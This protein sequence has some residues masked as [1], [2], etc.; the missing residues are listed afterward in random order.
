MESYTSQIESILTGPMVG[1]WSV[2]LLEALSKKKKARVWNIL[3]YP[4]T[5]WINGVPAH[6]NID[7]ILESICDVIDQVDPTDYKEHAEWLAKMV[8]AGSWHPFNKKSEM[9]QAL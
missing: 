6:T 7:A 3:T 8:R 4:D 9:A 5:S 2:L 1:P